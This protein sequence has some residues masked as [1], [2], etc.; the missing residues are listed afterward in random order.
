LDKGKKNE[1][2]PTQAKVIGSHQG[3]D[4]FLTNT[5]PIGYIY[6]ESKILIPSWVGFRFLVRYFLEMEPTRRLY[7]TS[8]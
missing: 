6:K 3:I 8:I 2:K 4:F 5:L 7:A 1:K